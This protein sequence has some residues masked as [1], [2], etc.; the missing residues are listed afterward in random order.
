MKNILTS[1]MFIFVINFIFSQTTVFWHEDI[2]SAKKE[3]LK[4]GKPLMLFFTGSD[5]CGWCIKLQKEVFKEEEF[6]KWANENVVLVDLDFPR[7]KEQDP[8]IKSQNLKL[9][10]QFNIMGFPTVVFASPVKENNELTLIEIGKRSG[11]MSGGAA[12]WCADA[13]Q[14]LLLD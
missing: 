6:A 3:S 4:T 9:Q 7:R 10:Q 14:K 8:T 5:W 2:E 11:Y 12:T 1:L 13:S